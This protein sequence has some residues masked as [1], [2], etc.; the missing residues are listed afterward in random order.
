MKKII[1][2]T[3]VYFILTAAH[4]CA[5][6]PRWKSMDPF[7]LPG[8]AIGG[9]VY[10]PEEVAL[11]LEYIFLHRNRFY[12]GHSHLSRSGQSVT[13]ITQNILF[14]GYRMGLFENLDFR[15]QVPLLDLDFE[16]SAGKSLATPHG[17]GDITPML[18][19]RI[20]NQ[21]KGAPLSLSTG[22]GFSI[23]SGET[24]DS[25]GVGY[26][27]W[28]LY[29]ELGITRKLP[30]QRIDAEFVYARR[31]KGKSYDSATDKAVSARQGDFVKA[32]IFYGFA[33]SHY[34]D[35]GIQWLS[36]WRDVNEK[37]HVYLPDTGG[38]IS[39]LG[40]VVHVKWLNH[41][42]FFSFSVPFCVYRDVNGHQLTTD[43]LFEFRF[44]CKF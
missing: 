30:R 1:L 26:G 12:S 9:E 44:K 16:N 13:A 5:E 38:I 37:N 21:K 43:W 17:I 25:N 29:A 42:T 33:T 19:Y 8:L 36:E 7:C 18:R 27:A 22:L 14:I 20:L 3:A 23:P 2:L 40:P 41:K 32:K 10:N 4:L 34:L 6:E 15:F 35:I 28:D 24:D 11:K 31:G 39:N